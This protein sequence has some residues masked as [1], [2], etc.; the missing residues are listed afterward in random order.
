MID[1]VTI[2]QDY[3]HNIFSLL[4]LILCFTAKSFLSSTTDVEILHVSIGLIEIDK[5]VSHDGC[6]S[7]QDLHYVFEDI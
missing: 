4:F 5:A 2:I 7:F 6:K 1:K 3:S